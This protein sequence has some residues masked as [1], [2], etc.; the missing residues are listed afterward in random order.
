MRAM[1]AALFL[2]AL[3]RCT[4]LAQDPIVMRISHQLPPAHHVS[5]IVDNLAAAI[6]AE[7]G[8]AVDVQVFGSDTAFSARENFPAVARG[9]IEAAMS[10]SVQWAGTIPEMN[11]LA[12]PMVYTS[13]D[14]VTGFLDSDARAYLDD[15]L[16]ARRIEPLAWLYQT[17]LSITTSNGRHLITPEDFAGVRI[18]GLNAIADAGSAAMGASPTAMPGSEVYQAL[19]TGI[20]DAAITGVAAGLARRYYEVQD[21]AVVAPLLTAFFTLYVNPAWFDGLPAEV[22]DQIRAAA[23]RVEREA[24]PFSERVISEA[25]DGLRAQGMNVAALTEEQAQV[26]RDIMT[27][28]VRAAYLDAAGE[29]GA[30]LLEMLD[31]LQ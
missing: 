10:V 1:I 9:Q 27:P 30:R 6:E 7:T 2:S 11:A 16:R 20:L 3:L 26:W 25:A 15:L 24:I 17:R 18:R 4:A 21:H 14:V 23:H 29:S 22:Q 13:E 5:T 28:A 19:Q 8:G 12:I 31:R